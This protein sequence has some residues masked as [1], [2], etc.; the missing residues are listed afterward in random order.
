MGSAE[1][2]KAS[3]D[4]DAEMELHQRSQEAQYN[5]AMSSLTILR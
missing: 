5:A 4:Q 1:D 2:W 3:M